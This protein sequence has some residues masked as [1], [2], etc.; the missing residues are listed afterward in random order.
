MCSC[1]VFI[2]VVYI[3]VTWNEFDVPMNHALTC[4]IFRKTQIPKFFL[5]LYFLEIPFEAMFEEE[6]NVVLKSLL[7]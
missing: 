3:R 1:F 2:G 4:H 5:T 6:L 7:V